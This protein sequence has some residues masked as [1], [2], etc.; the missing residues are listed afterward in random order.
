MNLRILGCSGGVAQGLRTTSLLI[1][2]SILIDAGSGVGDLTLDEMSRI[3][4]IFITHSHLDHISFLPLL[5]DSVF[6]HVFEP[7]TVHAQPITIKALKDHI[8]NWTIWPDFSTLPHPDKAVLQ[9]QEM[10]IQETRTIENINF[11]MIEMNHIVPTVGYLVE[12]G[13]KRFAFS[14]DTSTNDNF[15]QKLNECESLDMLIVETAFPE[16]EKDLAIIAKHYTPSLLAEDLKKLK[17]KPKIYLSHLKPGG[18]SQIID[19][20]NQLCPNI[21]CKILRNGDKFKL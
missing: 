14:A 6:D 11:H 20:V 3:K 12:Q 15:W 16:T 21:A 5:L 1:N 4:H 7:I 2:D 10:Q 8:F 17:L 13:E 19:E 9:F 18:E